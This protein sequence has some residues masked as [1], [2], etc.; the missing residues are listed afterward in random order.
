MWVWVTLMF[1]GFFLWPQ[2]NPRGWRQLGEL[3]VG[4]LGRALGGR[5][6]E[7]FRGENWGE[8]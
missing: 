5:V 1:F 3:Y 8:L 6:G 7:S 4:A 2:D